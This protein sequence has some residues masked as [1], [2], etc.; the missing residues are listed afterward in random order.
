MFVTFEWGGFHLFSWR[1]VHAEVGIYEFVYMIGVAVRLQFKS[2]LIWRCCCAVFR[3]RWLMTIVVICS[4]YLGIWLLLMI[5]QVPCWVQVRRG[6]E[7]S[8]REHHECLQ[9]CP[10]YCPRRSGSNPPHQAWARPQLLGVL[11]WDPELPWPRLQPCQA[12]LLPLPLSPFTVHGMWDRFVCVLDLHC[13]TV[14]WAHKRYPSHH[15][16]YWSLRWDF[17]YLAKYDVKEII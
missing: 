7:G 14:C 17:S 16:N 12:G 4:A 9:S 6:E 10:G 8:C 13:W 11:L 2:L 3:G 5:L 1:C 15:F